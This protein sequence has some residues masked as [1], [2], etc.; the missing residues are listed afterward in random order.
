MIEFFFQSL[1]ILNELPFRV[2]WSTPHSKLF[3]LCTFQNEH[4]QLRSQLMTT[5]NIFLTSMQQQS[6]SGVKRRGR[7]GWVHC[8]E[9]AVALAIDHNILKQGRKTFATVELIGDKTRGQ[10][11]I[12]DRI[13]CTQNENVTIATEIEK[14]LFLKYLKH[15]AH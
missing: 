5:K 1:E 15:A 10:M 9:I 14:E 2:Y 11:I 12:D 3:N 7:K 6:I 8:D 13:N 4:E